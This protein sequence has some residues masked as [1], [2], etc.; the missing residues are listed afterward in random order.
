MPDLALASRLRVIAG[1]AVLVAACSPAAAGPTLLT[2]QALLAFAARPYDRAAKMNTEEVVGVL[3]GVQVVA[4]YP[5][6]DICPDYTTRIIHFAIGP[7]PACVGAGGVANT[8]NV[9]VSIAV[10]EKTFCVP[11]VLAEPN[12]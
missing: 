2:D 12:P 3:N 4:D 9:P 7:G 8:R 5:C 10:E 11:K 1:V 6:S